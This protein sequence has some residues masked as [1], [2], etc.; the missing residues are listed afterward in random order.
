MLEASGRHLEAS[1]RHLEASGRHL[2][3][4]GMHLEAS[5]RHLEASWRHLE[6]SGRYLGD[7]GL[8]GIWDSWAPKVAPTRSEWYELFV[9]V[10]HLSYNAIFLWK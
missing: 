9:C 5:G 7:L 4:S 8:G 1:G 10:T 2:E 3:V 6:V